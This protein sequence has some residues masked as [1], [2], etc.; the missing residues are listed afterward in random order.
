MPDD[1]IYSDVYPSKKGIPCKSPPK[2]ITCHH[3]QYSWD[4]GHGCFVCPQCHTPYNP[5][6]AAKTD[7]GVQLLEA[8]KRTG[9]QKNELSRI[10]GCH[11]QTITNIES[12][13]TAGRK[14]QNG[15]SKMIF[16]RL[17]IWIESTK[18]PI[19]KR[20][21]IDDMFKEVKESNG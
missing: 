8:R 3:C 15:K 7:L 5:K 14:N 12:G 18:S 21:E 19:D 16:E 4:C 2:L 6:L 10:L 20:K 17:R 9:M 1:L 11:P 13:K